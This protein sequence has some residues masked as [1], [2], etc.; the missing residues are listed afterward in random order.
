MSQ[1]FEQ[2]QKGALT[3][4]QHKIQH[5]YGKLA[6]LNNWNRP[7]D[8]AV[9]SG[10]KDHVHSQAQSMAQLGTDAGDGARKAQTLFDDFAS[11]HQFFKA[12][13]PSASF[14]A[15]LK[16]LAKQQKHS[17]AEVSSAD[18]VSASVHAFAHLQQVR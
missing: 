12:A 2:P 11:P 4:A 8:Q 5:D 7:S 6:A 10:L 3:S 17:Q 16:S 13:K 9:L 15:E 1:Q 18:H 14:K